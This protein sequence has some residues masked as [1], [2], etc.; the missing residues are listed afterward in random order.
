[1]AY[2]GLGAFVT[3]CLVGAIAH[4]DEKT[5]AEEYLRISEDTVALVN[6]R[7]I[8]E[9]QL[10]VIASVMPSDIDVPEWEPEKT[11]EGLTLQD[12]SDAVADLSEAVSEIIT[13]E[14]DVANG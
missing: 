4:I 12:V 9:D 6:G 5:S 8:S 1:M 2:E 7:V 3:K 13:P 11:D 10:K 14:G